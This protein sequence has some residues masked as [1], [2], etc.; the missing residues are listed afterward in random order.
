MK[1]LLALAQIVEEDPLR[2]RF[3]IDPFFRDRSDKRENTKCVRSLALPMK[4]KDVAGAL[5]FVAGIVAIMGIITAEATYPGYSTAQ[6]DIS[7]LGATRPP[8]ST[9]KQPAATIFAA[10]LVVA[11]LLLIGGAL[12]TYRAFGNSRSSGLLALFLALFGV[13]AIG[14]ALFNGSNDA[15]L[16]VHTLFALL[17]FS[18]GAIA[19]IA[20]SV[21]VRSPFRYISI[22]LGVIALAGL[23]LVIVFGDVNPV[24]SAI[25]N[26]GAERW[27]AYPSVL[28]VIG[29]GGYLMGAPANA[30]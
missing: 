26:G 30:E 4:Y 29:F 24:F 5:L 27:I 15:S 1:K 2:Y 7:D 28:W 11:G 6:N 14:V 23:V 18:A 13:G 8:N 3:H 19:A 22:V 25:G 21:V 9:I 17:T 12:C 10:T 16:V 20:A